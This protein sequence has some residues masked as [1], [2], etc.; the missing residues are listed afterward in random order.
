MRACRH[1]RQD[2][3]GRVYPALKSVLRDDYDLHIDDGLAGIQRICEQLG[4]FRGSVVLAI[5]APVQELSPKDHNAQLLQ[6]TFP[7]EAFTAVRF[8][9]GTV[10]WWDDPVISNHKA[11]I[12]SDPSSMSN[13]VL[14]REGAYES[15]YVNGRCRFWMRIFLTPEGIEV[16]IFAKLVGAGAVTQPRF[17]LNQTVHSLCLQTEVIY[18]L[19]HPPSPRNSSS[20]LTFLS[21]GVYHRPRS[22]PSSSFPRRCQPTGPITTSCSQWFCHSTC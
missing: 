3:W 17:N 15:W 9:A 4:I 18:L 7:K 21:I 11:K 8:P 12:V 14:F 5:R 6:S 2:P 10:L 19:A 20:S 22:S 1:W 13:E 16:R